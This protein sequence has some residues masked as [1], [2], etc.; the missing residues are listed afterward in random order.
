[1]HDGNS[2]SRFTRGDIG[3]RNFP[4]LDECQQFDKQLTLGTLISTIHREN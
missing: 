4:M 3:R 1:M 2:T